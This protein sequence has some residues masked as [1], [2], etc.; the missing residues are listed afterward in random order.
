MYA[1]AAMK[2]YQSVN[3]NAQLVDASPH[4]LIQMLM[5]G[6]LARMAQARG[7]MERGDVALKGMLIGKAV[8]IVGGLREALN[9]EAGGE[10]A[11]NLDNLYAYMTARLLEANLKNDQTLLDEVAEL[12]REVKAG[13]DGI[14]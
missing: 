2:Q 9:Q 4:R 8:D 7:A 6:G 13:W 1:M 12:L 3:T 11:A 10:V 14:A 5:E